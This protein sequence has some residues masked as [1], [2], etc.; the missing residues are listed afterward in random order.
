M[1]F[2]DSAFGMGTLAKAI[3]GAGLLAIAVV[4]VSVIT[5]PKSGSTANVVSV[6]SNG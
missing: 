4:L 2:I 1:G 5:W 3:D 6:V